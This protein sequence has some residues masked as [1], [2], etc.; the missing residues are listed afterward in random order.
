M[1]KQHVHVEE[2][3]VTGAGSIG[4]PEITYVG[5]GR[6]SRTRR[7][8]P[9]PD[10]I[11]QSGDEANAARKRLMNEFLAESIRI[12]EIGNVESRKELSLRMEAFMREE[13]TMERRLERIERSLEQIRRGEYMTAE[14]ADEAIRRDL[15]WLR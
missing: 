11:S 8:I 2:R 4:E 12:Y 10:G 1:E 7:D 13:N 3:K 9:R 15:P 6:R 5:Q 14:E